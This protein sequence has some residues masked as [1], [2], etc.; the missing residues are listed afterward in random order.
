MF[1]NSIESFRFCS[2][3]IEITIKLLVILL[4]ERKIKNNIN[5]DPHNEGQGN[6]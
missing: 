6:K 3:C 1:A 4:R 2:V 5:K